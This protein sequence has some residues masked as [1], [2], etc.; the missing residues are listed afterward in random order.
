M[1]NNEKKRILREGF[2]RIFISFLGVVF[3]MLMCQNECK[4]VLGM[5]FGLLHCFT[6]ILS[7][8]GS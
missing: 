5:F 3:N 1:N 4:R 2:N 7:L 6:F 8:S